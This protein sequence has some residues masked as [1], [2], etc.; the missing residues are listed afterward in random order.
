MSN[1]L[2]P[3]VSDDNPAYEPPEVEEIAADETTATNPGVPYLG[4]A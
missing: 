2:Q 1:D 3:P 4:L